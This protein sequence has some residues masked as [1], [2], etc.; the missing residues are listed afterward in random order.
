MSWDQAVN[1]VEPDTRPRQLIEWNRAP[2]QFVSCCRLMELHSLTLA[3]TFYPFPAI[4][5]GKMPV[6]PGTILTSAK[7]ASSSCCRVS[8]LVR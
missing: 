2:S 7:P 5:V 8:S 3:A 4:T 6:F 1:E